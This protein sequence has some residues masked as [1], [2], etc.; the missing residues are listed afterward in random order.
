MPLVLMLVAV[1]ATLVLLFPRRRMQLEGAGPP[2]LLSL[3]YLRV[4]VRANPMLPAP[5]LLLAEQALALGQLDEAAAA[6]ALLRGERGRAG[7]RA[8]L[9]A[10]DLSVRRWRA[11]A[12]GSTARRRLGDEVGRA[13][14]AAERDELPPTALRELAAVALEL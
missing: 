11:A 8:R 4:S 7:D 1:A 12:A 5:R 14:A 3:A 6:L 9:L 2:D 13:L 10:L